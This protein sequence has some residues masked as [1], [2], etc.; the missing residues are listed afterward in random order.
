MT[1]II[2]IHGSLS[3]HIPDF[4]CVSYKMVF[5]KSLNWFTQTR[6]QRMASMINRFQRWLSSSWNRGVTFSSSSTASINISKWI[7]INN[8][9][10][11]ANTTFQ[12]LQLKYIVPSKRKMVTGSSRRLIQRT[13]VCFTF[14]C[15]PMWSRTFRMPSMVGIATP[16]TCNE[17]AY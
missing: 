3:L 10:L 17:S 13:C 9:A 15:A 12:T 5:H 4:K 1:I 14:I 8:Q 7:N 6:H 11:S 16:W 2:F